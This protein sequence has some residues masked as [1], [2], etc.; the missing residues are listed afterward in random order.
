MGLP[1]IPT[2]LSNVLRMTA[3][4]WLSRMDE[5]RAEDNNSMFDTPE[6]PTKSNS[7]LKTMMRR[8]IRPV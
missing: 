1:L 2:M 6:I 4:L 5:V 3:P 8:N 7:E